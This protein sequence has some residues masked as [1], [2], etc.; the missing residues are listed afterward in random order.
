MASEWLVGDP[1]KCSVV[2]PT[3]LATLQVTDVAGVRSVVQ[4]PA[5]VWLS[6]RLVSHRRCDVSE[7]HWRRE[8]E[9]RITGVLRQNAG[10]S[11]HIMAGVSLANLPTSN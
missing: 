8:F 5:S 7:A 11:K 1:F 10:I 6:G 4:I 9:S 3:G 2:R